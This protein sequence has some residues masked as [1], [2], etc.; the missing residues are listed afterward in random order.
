MTSRGIAFIEYN[1]ASECDAALRAMHG[2]TLPGRW[3]AISVHYARP[4]PPAL[5]PAIISPSISNSSDILEGAPESVASGLSPIPSGQWTYS[6]PSYPMH[7][8]GITVPFPTSPRMAVP[9]VVSPTLSTPFFVDT[10]PPQAVTFP[11]GLREASAQL[12]G[13]P[14]FATIRL[15]YD[16]FSPYGHVLG[17]ELNM[18]ITRRPDGSFHEVS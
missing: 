10:G 3:A 15:L 13:L 1:L 17:A 8:I 16:V 9:A 6:V 18:S 7:A 2:V 4:P 11:A 14:P 12:S 5:S